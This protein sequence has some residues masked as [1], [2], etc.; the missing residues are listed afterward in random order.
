LYSN[1]KF[2]NP[3]DVKV[4]ANTSVSSIGL[5]NNIDFLNKLNG[6]NLMFT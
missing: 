6:V 5:D 3:T 1:T 2:Y 4:S